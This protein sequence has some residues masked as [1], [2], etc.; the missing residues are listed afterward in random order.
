M[1]DLRVWHCK[2]RR[3]VVRVEGH[4]EN[5]HNLKFDRGKEDK[6]KHY[7]KRL[8]SP[9]SGSYRIRKI[10][11]R[12]IYNVKTFYRSWSGIYVQKCGHPENCCV[13]NRP[14]VAWPLALIKNLLRFDA[15]KCACCWSALHNSLR[16]WRRVLTLDMSVT[17]QSRNGTRQ[18]S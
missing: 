12:G 1:R 9:Q 13:L 14:K 8:K 10:S 17:F 7:Q 16:G 2:K 15:K 4:P 18:K 5:N 11:L 3:P 6:K